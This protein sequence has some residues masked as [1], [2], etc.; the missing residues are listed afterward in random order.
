ME[1]SPGAFTSYGSTVKV[2]R[3]HELVYSLYRAGAGPDK[4]LVRDGLLIFIQK[5]VCHSVSLHFVPCV[6][7]TSWY[8]IVSGT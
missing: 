8:Y 7:F 5:Y 4:L 6:L 2:C 3:N 1:Y